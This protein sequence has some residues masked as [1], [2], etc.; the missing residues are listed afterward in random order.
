MNRVL[1]VDLVI[2][3]QPAVRRVDNN[4]RSSSSSC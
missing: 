2:I 1:F 3:N 4:Y